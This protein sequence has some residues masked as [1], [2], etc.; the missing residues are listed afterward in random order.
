[1]REVS[2]DQS[3][4]TPSLPPPCHIKGKGENHRLVYLQYHPYGKGGFGLWDDVREEAF[5]MPS[6]T[7]HASHQDHQPQK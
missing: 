3:T 6:S 7:E 5:S 1:M 4:K 2:R